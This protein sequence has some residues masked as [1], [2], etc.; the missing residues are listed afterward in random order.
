[1]PEDLS[2]DEPVSGGVDMDPVVGEPVARITSSGF[3]KVLLHGAVEIDDVPATA[4]CASN[5][6]EYRSSTS[7]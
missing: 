1:M 2:C 5:H 3:G 7:S 4:F 6:S